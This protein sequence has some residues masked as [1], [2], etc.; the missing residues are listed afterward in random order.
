MPTPRTL[1]ARRPAETTAAAG[2]LALLIAYALGV[3]EPTII[4]AGAGVLAAVPA[5]V[6]WW[7]ELRRRR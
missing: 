2:G 7:V 5:A 1:P 6:T 3:D 4:L